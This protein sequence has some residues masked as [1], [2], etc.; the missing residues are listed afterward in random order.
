M[1]VLRLVT[2]GKIVIEYML[3]RGIEDGDILIG[4]PLRRDGRA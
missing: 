1:R 4:A 2:Q 3:E